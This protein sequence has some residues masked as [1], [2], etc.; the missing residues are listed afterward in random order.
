VSCIVP[1]Y[2]CIAVSFG[3]QYRSRR[4]FLPRHQHR[5][6]YATLVLS[7]GYEE[8]GDRG[9]FR[10][11]AGDVLF[12]EAFES[13]L[14]RYGPV[15]SEVLNLG[16]AC[17]VAPRSVVMQVPDPDRIVRLAERSPRE[18]SDLLFGLMGPSNCAESSWPDQLAEALQRDPHLALHEW[19]LTHNLSNAT[20]SRGFEKVYGI[21]PSGYRAQSKAR[22]AWRGSVTGSETFSA[23]A[24]GAG[25]SDQAHMTRGVRALTGKTPGAWRR[26]GQ[27]DSIQD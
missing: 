7:G 20:V 17:F 25:F 26:I 4:T 14:D 22:L 6:S 9:R 11:R 5:Y 2:R 8:A 27:V 13:H 15:D 16:P 18:A 19:A 12:H 23:L 24:L 1:K 3:R 21:S 10:V